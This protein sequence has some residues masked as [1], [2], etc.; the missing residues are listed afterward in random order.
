MLYNGE[1]TA[2]QHGMP[3]ASGSLW[4]YMTSDENG[5]PAI[6]SQMAHDGNSE[7]WYVDVP[8]GY[9]KIRFAS[10][11]VVNDAV[12]GNGDGTK[13]WEIPTKL[14]KP[15]FYADTSD[16]VIYQGGNRGG[17]WG[18]KGAIR[19]AESGKKHNRCGHCKRKIHP[20]GGHKVHHQHP[21]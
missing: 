5:K 10:W 17:Y 2:V 15:C 7:I 14:S 8:E 12:A 11:E 1:G 20:R 18:E 13:M 9:T 21:L 3:G 19:D 4:C 16:D 6:T